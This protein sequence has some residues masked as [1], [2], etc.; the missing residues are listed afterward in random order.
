MLTCS[1]SITVGVLA[2]LGVTE[3]LSPFERQKELMA[4]IRTVGLD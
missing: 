4:T 3:I 1:I 2:R